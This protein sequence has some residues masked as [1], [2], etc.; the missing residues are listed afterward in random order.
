MFSK[1]DIVRAMRKYSAM[2]VTSAS[3]AEDCLCDKAHYHCYDHFYPD[4]L[5]KY[6][7]RENLNILEIGAYYGGSVLLWEELFPGATIY[8]VDWNFDNLK[9]DLNRDNIKKIKMSQSDPA[10]KNLLKDV[11][12]DIIIDDASHRAEDQIASFNLL[13]DLLND[14]G[15]Y[16]I[17][18]VYPEHIRNNKYP[19]AFLSNFEHVDLS[20]IKGRGDDRLFVFKRN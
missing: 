13:S 17:E 10:L 3:G 19:A 8:A 15:V 2:K 4:L 16:V 12:F 18:D 6:L 5:E 9:V 7:N 14:E 1:E 11:K 20:D